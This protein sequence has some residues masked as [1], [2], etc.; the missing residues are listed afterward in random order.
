M[1]GK[2]I[3]HMSSGSISAKNRAHFPPNSW[4]LLAINPLQTERRPLYLKTQS[5]RAV[6]TFHLS[7]KT[8]QFMLYGAEFA[9]CSEMNTEH[10]NTVWAEFK[11]FK[12]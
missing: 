2:T 3:E 1:F 5:Y 10:I 7:C 6:N 8:N 9:L 11:I 4:Y 12:C